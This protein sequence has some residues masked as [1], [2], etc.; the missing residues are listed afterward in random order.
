MLRQSKHTMTQST[1]E[2]KKRFAT[3]TIFIDE[4]TGE[5]IAK[6][7]QYKYYVARTEIRYEAKENWIIK[8]IIKIS[9]NLNQIEMFKDEKT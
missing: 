2:Q 8:K 1:M 4:D 5:V 7:E 6:R 3:E 9:R